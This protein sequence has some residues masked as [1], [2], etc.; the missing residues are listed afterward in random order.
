[1]RMFKLV[2]SLLL[3][4]SG[5]ALGVWYFFFYNA[6]EAVIRRLFDEALVLARKNGEK[7]PV[8]EAADFQGLRELAE[9]VLTVSGG[10]RY[11]NGDFSSRELIQQFIAG[12]RFLKTLDVEL[13]DMSVSV[14]D[15]G[16]A[17]VAF[18]LYVSGLTHTDVRFQDFFECSAVLIRQRRGVWT[19]R[20]VKLEPVVRQHNS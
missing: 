2:F 7:Q 17:E 20:S 3:L 19:L 6:E 15:D 14:K 8:V 16:T 9:P 13:E 1:M 12:R 5:I 11:A 10:N 18:T 4:L